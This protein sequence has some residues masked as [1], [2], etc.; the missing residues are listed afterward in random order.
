VTACIA[1]WLQVLAHYV[2]RSAGCSACAWW[3]AER[4]AWGRVWCALEAYSLLYDTLLQLA[5]EF[6]FTPWP[7]EYQWSEVPEASWQLTTW[8]CKTAKHD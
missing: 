6:L 3:C 7:S 4:F 8:R 1:D 2:R 5:A